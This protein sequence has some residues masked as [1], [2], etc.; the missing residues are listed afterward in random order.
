MGTKKQ[1]CT[2]KKRFPA[3]EEYFWPSGRNKDGFQSRCKNCHNLKEDDIAEIKVAEV[4]RTKSIFQERKRAGADADRLN[5]VIQKCLARE[6]DELNDLVEDHHRLE[7][8]E[9]AQHFSVV[10]AN[11]LPRSGGEFLE[12]EN[13]TA[14]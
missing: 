13:V 7:L 4:L 11:E 12:D 10:W 5:A 14:G 9:D 2:C 1:C 6:I 8:L 3:T